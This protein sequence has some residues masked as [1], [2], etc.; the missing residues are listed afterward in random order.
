MGLMD[1]LCMNNGRNGLSLLL[2]DPTWLGKASSVC[3]AVSSFLS[4]L[5]HEGKWNE[6]EINK[7]FFSFDVLK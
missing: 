7:A 1:T 6:P 4:T 3:L 5:C 2:S